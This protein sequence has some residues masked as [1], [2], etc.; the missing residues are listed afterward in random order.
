MAEDYSRQKEKKQD[1]QRSWKVPCMVVAIIMMCGIVA[2]VVGL[3]FIIGGTMSGGPAGGVNPFRDVDRQLRGATEGSLAHSAPDTMWRDEPT[4]LALLVGALTPEELAGSLVADYPAYSV[5]TAEIQITPRMAAELTS[6]DP[7]A[8]LIRPL[9]EQEQPISTVEETKWTWVV[10]PLK[11]G[12]RELNLVVERLI[13]ID[14]EDYWRPVNVYRDTIEVKVNALGRWKDVR[15]HW[16]LILPPII[17][18]VVI[19]YLRK[20]WKLP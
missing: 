13:E 14:D 19:A 8:F 6:P 20:R 2:V 12:T 3:P 16:P 17:V 1:K 11:S 4:E 9:S 5:T 15:Q 10:I 7:E 18:G